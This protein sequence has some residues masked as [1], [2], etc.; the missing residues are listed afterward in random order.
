MITLSK[1][2]IESYFSKLTFK[3]GSHKYFVDNIPLTCSVSNLYSRFSIPFDRQGES[4]KAAKRRG[5]SQQEVLKE[6]DLK[7]DTACIK[8]NKAHLF[9][10]KYPF[11]RAMIPTTPQEKAIVKFWNDLPDYIIPVVM[12]LKMYHIKHLFG[13]TADILLYN[14]LTETFIIGDYK[15]NEKLFKNYKGKKLKSPFNNLLETNYNKYQLQLSFYQI[16]LEQIE[17]IKVSS[18]KIVWLKDNGEYVLYDTT[19]YTKELIKYLNK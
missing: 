2:N 3:E 10:E 8:G 19:D 6:W 15:T 16:L 7:R 11:N 17:G 5:I 14:T 12:E 4:L 1:E 13:G 9:G 18:R